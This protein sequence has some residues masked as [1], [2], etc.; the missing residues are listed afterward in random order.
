[1]GQVVSEILDEAITT[2]RGSLTVQGV[3][4]PMEILQLDHGV[5]QFLSHAIYDAIE[6]RS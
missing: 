1:M 2:A 4:L 3:S 6:T 5:T